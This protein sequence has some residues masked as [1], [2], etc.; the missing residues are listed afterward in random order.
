MGKYKVCQ[1]CNKNCYNG[2]FKSPDYEINFCSRKCQ[3][4]YYNQIGVPAERGRSIFWIFVNII[5]VLGIILG[6]VYLFTLGTNSSVNSQKQFNQD[7]SSPSNLPIESIPIDEEAV[8]TN[9]FT[10]D[11][12]LNSIKDESINPSSESTS[13][14]MG[15][16]DSKVMFILN[17]ITNSLK[18]NDIDKV[19]SYFSYEISTYHNMNNTTK[20]VV[21]D[22]IINYMNRWSLV[23]EKILEL[24]KDN[25]EPNLFHYSKLFVV[26]RRN[27]PIKEL[28][29]KREYKINGFV[30]FNQ[31]GEIIK[32]KDVKTERL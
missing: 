2:Y 14:I 21:E 29:N 16:S 4:Q 13:T 22:E 25:N 23:D 32:L 20:D 10:N 6:V 27:T 19:M 8:D 3:T 24:Y 9:N 15:M 26:V 1:W 30:Q 31:N 28:D 12:T 18:I 7:L 5:I 17:D 11:N